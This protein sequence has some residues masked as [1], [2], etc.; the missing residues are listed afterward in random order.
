MKRLLELGRRLA[1]YWAALL[2]GMFA[3]ILGVYFSILLGGIIYYGAQ[4]AISRDSTPLVEFLSPIDNLREQKRTSFYQDQE[5][6]TETSAKDFATALARIRQQLEIEIEASQS[7]SPDSRIILQRID[8][9]EQLLMLNPDEVVSV[10]VQAQRLA[11]LE[12]SLL[13][14]ESRIQAQISNL[15]TIVIGLFGALLVAVVGAVLFRT[16]GERRQT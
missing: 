10:A 13:G 7:D 11:A 4:S 9:L 12:A 6:V 3:I 14:L 16:G 8:A 2:V 1:T 15:Y 5:G